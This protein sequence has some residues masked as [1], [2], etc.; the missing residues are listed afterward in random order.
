MKFTK[1]KINGPKIIEL[2]LL[3]DSRGFFARQFCQEE[4]KKNGL[5]S[6]ILQ[7]NTSFCRKKGTLRGLHFQPEPYGEVKFLRCISGEI[8]DFL[9]DVRKDSPTYLDSFSIVLSSKNRVAIYIPEGFAH[10]YMSLTNNAEVM[11]SSSQQYLPGV[12]KGIRWNDPS[13]KL[14]LPFEPINVSEKDLSHPNI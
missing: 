2:D 13:I 1:V 6:A 3:N 7:I 14:D 12:E 8:V 10:G 9:V 4:F 5:N 11:Y